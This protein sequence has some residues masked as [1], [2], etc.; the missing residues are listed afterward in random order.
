MHQA[1]H[2]HAFISPFN[3][4][5]DSITYRGEKE[6]SNM[7]PFHW[8]NLFPV[9][10]E[11]VQTPRT[12]RG[13]QHWYKQAQPTEEFLHAGSSL[14][15]EVPSL[16]TNTHTTIISVSQILNRILQTDGNGKVKAAKTWHFI[17]TFML[18]I[19]QGIFKIQ[20]QLKSRVR[21]GGWQWSSQK[22][23]NVLKNKNTLRPEWNASGTEA[24]CVVM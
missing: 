10:Q 3:P 16:P 14:L 1:K 12:I 11:S 15:E 5:S 23:E 19:L 20:V 22:E 13:T 4:R 18:L 2:T 6:E 8:Q 9:F 17:F 24:R 21:V 7:S